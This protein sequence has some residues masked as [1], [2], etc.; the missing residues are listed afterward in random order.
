MKNLIFA[1]ILALPFLVSCSKQTACLGYDCVLPE[2]AVSID[3]VSSA[4]VHVT[5]LNQDGD[6]YPVTMHLTD[7]Q[8]LSAF[9]A[10]VEAGETSG[11]PQPGETSGY[12]NSPKVYYISTNQEYVRTNARYVNASTTTFEIVAYGTEL[13]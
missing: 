1:A 6:D 4:G 12:T 9:Q 13:D 10:Y 3:S 7:D 11:M 5:L 2:D 8:S